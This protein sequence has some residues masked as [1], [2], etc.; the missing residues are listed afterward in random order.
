M[1]QVRHGGSKTQQVL[2]QG[3]SNAMVRSGWI[4]F[5]LQFEGKN[6]GFWGSDA[7]CERK[8]GVKSNSMLLSLSHQESEV[9]VF[10]G[11][12]MFQLEQQCGQ[13][14][15]KEVEDM[16]QFINNWP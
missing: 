9:P 13:N 6:N 5:S 16:G 1:I 2:D 8:R 7:G 14:V 3:S 4:G 11:D 15:Q 12:N 10:S